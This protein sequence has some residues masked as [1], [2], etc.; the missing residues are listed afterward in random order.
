M[1]VPV[2]EQKKLALASG[3][4]CAFPGCT[5]SLTEQSATGESIIVGEIAHII[6]DSRQGPRGV[7]LLTDAERDLS[8]NLIYLCER[9]HKVVDE[10]SRTYSVEVLRQ[11]KRDHESRVSKLYERPQ[12]P[13]TVALVDETI[14]STLLRISALPAFVYSAPCAFAEGQEK[15][16]SDRIKYPFASDEMVPFILRDKRLYCFHPLVDKDS[17]FR[18]VV[19]SRRSEPVPITDFAADDE[20]NRRLVNLLNRSLKRFLV[21]RNVGYDKLHSRYHFNIT[22]P[23]QERSIEYLSLQGRRTSR[24]VVWQP[25]SKA[26]KEPKGYWLHLAAGLRFEQLALDQWGFSIRIERHITT[27][28]ITPLAAEYVGPKVTR[29][30]ARLFN[31]IYLGEVHFWRD[32]LSNGRPRFILNFGQQSCIVES[33]LV[34]APIRW[35]GIPEDT[36]PFT[37]QA[38]SDDLFSYA[39]FRSALDGREVEWELDLDEEENDDVAS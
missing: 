28:G 18:D 3:N 26:T 22:A 4:L 33:E 6:G 17:P 35:P 14:H 11:M 16:V 13:D 10:L 27:D 20:G 9:H 19:D 34:A 5:A 37:N 39:E 36:K 32:F 25:R 23:D 24:N 31:D 8:E 7:S 38:F 1:S 12:P 29:L 15:E 30:K 2:R 21:M